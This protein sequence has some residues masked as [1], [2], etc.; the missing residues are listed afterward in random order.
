VEVICT[1]DATAG[2]VAAL[3]PGARIE[4]LPKPLRWIATA[5]EAV[6]LRKLVVLIFADANDVERAEVFAV[7][8]TDAEAALRS[9]R[10]LAADLGDRS[11]R[12]GN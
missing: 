4:P 5:L 6:E 8:C 10:T 9:F 3:Y 11:W 12:D 2:E 7:A 1:P